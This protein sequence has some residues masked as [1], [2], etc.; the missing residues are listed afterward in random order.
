MNALKCLLLLALALLLG[1]TRYVL[2]FALAYGALRTFSFGVHLSKP[3]HCTLLGLAY[4][5]GSAFLA[6]HVTFP[7]WGKAIMLALCGIAF[8]TLSPAETE[9]R[10]IPK[11]KRAGYKAKSCAV[12]LAVGVL[13]IMLHQVAPTYSSLLCMALLCQSINLLPIT[14]KIIRRLERNETIPENH[15]Q[16]LR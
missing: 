5:L 4:Y 11:R 1:I 7:L 15:V 10:P 8:A 12:L 14:Y 6:Q 2:V 13:C 16:T 3:F 9:K